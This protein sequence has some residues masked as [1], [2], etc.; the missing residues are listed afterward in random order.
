MAGKAEGPWTGWMS[1]KFPLEI[2]AALGLTMYCPESAAAAA[3]RAGSGGELCRAG[4]RLGCSGELCSYVRMGTA[5]A[6]A[7]GGGRLPRPRFLLCCNNICAGMVQW[8]QAMSRTL[9]VPLFLLDVPYRQGEPA[10]PAG[11]AYLGEQLREIARRL[12]DLTGRRWEEDRFQAACRQANRNARLWQRVLDA[13][14]RRPS[15][16][17]NMEVFDY[18][19]LMVTG[20]CA[21]ETEERLTALLRE[22]EARPVDER[23]AGDYRIFWE[24]TPCWPVLDQVLPLLEERHIQVVSDTLSPSLSFRYGDWAGMLRAFWSTINGVPLEEGVAMRADLCRRFQAEGVL[25]HYN[26]SCRP[27][28]GDLQEVERRLRRELDLPTAAFDGDQGDP[29]GFSLAQFATRLDALVDL[30]AARRAAGN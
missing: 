21:P 26:R 24:G 4:E 11:L 12:A 8:Y 22:L 17:Q 7:G 5:L 3:A 25:V 14:R 28:C 2:P 10:S 13:A 1:T 19:P 27:W 16:L 30:M 18:M 15:P 9:D 23:R 29:A 20:R 6:E